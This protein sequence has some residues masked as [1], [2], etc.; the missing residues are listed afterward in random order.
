MWSHFITNTWFCNSVDTELIFS[1]VKLKSSPKRYLMNWIYRNV[2][3][4]M[5]NHCV[6]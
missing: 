6:I 4:C 2:N 5:S 3:K 1:G